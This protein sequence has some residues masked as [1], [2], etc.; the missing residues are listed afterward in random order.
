[1]LLAAG[2]VKGRRLAAYWALKPD[3][4]AA[5]ATFVDQEAVVDGNL[6]TARAWIDHPAV[7]REFIRLLRQA[8]VAA[9]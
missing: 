7:L 4:E 9:A 2:V 1:M 6:V 5:G 3:V 8:G